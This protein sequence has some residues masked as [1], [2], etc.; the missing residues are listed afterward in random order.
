MSNIKYLQIY[1][2]TLEGASRMEKIATSV[3]PHTGADQTELVGVAGAQ[4]PEV[5]EVA[6]GVSIRRIA[7]SARPGNLG[8]VLRVL[9]WQPRVYRHYRNQPLAAVAAHNV[10]VL[11][12][13]WHL[14]RRAEAPLIY[15]PH[16]LET[17][18]CAMRGM[19]KRAAQFLES[20]YIKRCALVS[21]VNEPI[22]DWYAERYAIT[23]PVTVSNIPRVKEARP[24][25][26]LRLG[27]REDEML[28]IHTGHL[29]EGRSIRVMLAAFSRSHH[30]VVFLGD[31][32][33]RAAVESAALAHS[34]IHWM[35][36]VHPDLVVAHVREADVGLCLTET[37]EDL[38]NLYATPNKLMETL[39]AGR[40]ALCTPLV[41]AQRILGPANSHW[42]VAD[43]GKDLDDALA[44]IT[45]A[46]VADFV[47]SWPGLGSWDEEVQQ[48]VSAYSSLL[49]SSRS[50]SDPTTRN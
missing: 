33:L 10:W 20:R 36:P 6:P 4:L 34:N 37:Q 44:R 9:L 3:H 17:E 5:D 14:A 16:E 25:L 26:R 45:K 1:P 46:V 11:A 50:L 29:V 42:I 18:T 2:S 47:E 19:K 8:R 7:G 27:I 21:V 12:L 49:V 28:Y 39:L 24:N 13:C 31:G 40:P 35:M 23:R 48:L 43:P 32:H 41:E 15:N 38:S 22:A 30:H